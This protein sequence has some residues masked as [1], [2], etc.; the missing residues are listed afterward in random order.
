MQFPRD[1]KDLLIYAPSYNLIPSF[2]IL[3]PRSEPARSISE[4]LP[5][6]T[7]SWLNDSVLA[8]VICKTAC[9]LEDVSFALVDS[10]I[11]L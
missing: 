3:Q 9:D 6:L 1:S 10:Y 4:N 7:L 5:T 2:P 8:T 11:L